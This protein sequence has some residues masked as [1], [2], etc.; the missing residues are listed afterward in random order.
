MAVRHTQGGVQREHNLAGCSEEVG[1]TDREG[2][3]SMSPCC[4]EGR[5]TCEVG[6]VQLHFLTSNTLFAIVPST[7]LPTLISL[8]QI[9]PPLSLSPVASL[10][11][12]LNS[13]LHPGAGH[14]QTPVRVRVFLSHTTL[15]CVS[16]WP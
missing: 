7:S 16:I 4:L 2:V 1:D 10:P 3:P 9:N 14:T 8:Y 6:R 12:S 5:W 11:L 13:R 15:L